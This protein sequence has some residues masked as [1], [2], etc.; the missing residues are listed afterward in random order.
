MSVRDVAGRH[1]RLTRGGPSTDG[2]PA[3]RD[4]TARNSAGRGVRRQARPI[5]ARSGRRAPG[6]LIACLV[7][8][9]VAL[10]EAVT[11]GAPGRDQSGVIALGPSGQLASAGGPSRVASG[12]GLVAN[13]HPAG[14][15]PLRNPPS[16]N[17][18]ADATGGP[19]PCTHGDVAS[20]NA[21]LADWATTLV[22]TSFVLPDGYHPPDL[23]PVGQA[24]IDGW[25]LVRSFVI[26]DLRA[27]AEAAADAGHPLAV[28]SAYRA[29]DRQA[30]VF[31]GW[32]A[33]SGESRARQF[34]ARPGHSEH[35]LGTALDVRAAGGGAPWTGS[36]GSTAAGRWLG[37]HGPEFGFVQSYSEGDDA[38][39]C[40]GA[41]AWHIRYVGR[42]I[43]AEVEASGLPLRVWLWR[44]GRDR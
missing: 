5:G 28:Q 4:G 14:D 13:T 44:F 7:V 39:T 21:R 29:R 6:P 25:G 16:G 1:P 23:V 8:L 35:Q 31:A 36:F 24:G 40:Y 20:P 17:A 10:A 41:E 12:P 18:A 22:D 19:P 33:S 43:A 42:A 3:T 27:L 26:D 30:D 11:I 34:S 37:Q 2:W 15:A 32:V 9:V 38:V